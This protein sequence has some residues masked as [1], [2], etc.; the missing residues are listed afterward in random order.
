MTEQGHAATGGDPASRRAA[1]ADSIQSMDVSALTSGPADRIASVSSQLKPGLSDESQDELA[2]L[3]GLMLDVQRERQFHLLESVSAACASLINLEPP[4]VALARGMRR[5]IEAR[6]GPR[7]VRLMRRNPPAL[8]VVFSLV[9][10]LFLA[11]P[12]FSLLSYQ[13]FIRPLTTAPSEV[14]IFEIA[15]AWIIY[16]IV[17]AGALGSVTSIMVRIQDFNKMIDSDPMILLLTG[18]F[19]PVIGVFFALFIFSVNT[20]GIIAIPVGNGNYNAF[21][22]ALAFIAGFSERFVKDVT[23]RLEKL[24]V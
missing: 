5:E 18:L 13:V 17:L 7:W 3:L 10:F 15:A 6:L 20:A 21:L 19:K 16:M 4:N 9:L 14:Q 1:M 12:I 22:F 24:P 11:I 8:S 2:R 23:S